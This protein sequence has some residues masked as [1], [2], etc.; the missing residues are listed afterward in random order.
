[1]PKRN[2][3]FFEA[4]LKR[5]FGRGT[6]FL[7]GCRL[8]TH[9]RRDEH[10]FPKWLQ[11]QYELWD[12][13]L[14]LLN[15]T[16]IPYRKLTVPCCKDCNSKH[17]EPFEK[18][19]ARAVRK[20]PRAVRALDPYCV[21]IWLGKIFYGLLYRELFLPWDRTQKLKGNIAPK[22]LLKEYAMH[23]LFLQSVRVPMRFENFFPASILILETEEPKGD[24]TRAW[25]FSD[26]P[27]TMSI[28]CRMGKVGIICALQDG[29]AQQQLH[30]PQ[31]KKTL[32]PKLDPMQFREV[33][34]KVRYM[35]RLFNR[36]PKY[37]IMKGREGPYTVVQNPLQGYSSKPLFDPWEQAEY[38]KV[39]SAMTRIPVEHLF[40][41][42]DLVW[43]WLMGNQRRVFPISPSFA[44]SDSKLRGDSR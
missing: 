1:M 10:V 28:G 29:G 20:G 17:L 21:F 32:P 26:N 42:P 24:P 41:P 31:L 3:H 16:S 35:A 14:V 37:F 23:H 33:M 9:N 25:D 6:C 5:R 43:T 36:I 8:T 27:P 19:M 39:L 13:N 18:I 40:H 30:F 11:K 44:D 12:E 15:G 4:V 2:A 34:A 38:V 22:W 7:C